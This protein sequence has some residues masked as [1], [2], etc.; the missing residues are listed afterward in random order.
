MLVRL[1]DGIARLETPHRLPA[2]FLENPFRLL[3]LQR[4]VQQFAFRQ[5]CPAADTVR[6]P[7]M[8]LFHSR[9]RVLQSAKHLLDVRVRHLVLVLHVD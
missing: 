6:A 3:R 5:P 8:L 7:L 1:V 4:P 2:L 9:V